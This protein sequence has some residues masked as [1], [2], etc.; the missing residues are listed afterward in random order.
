M[1]CTHGHADHIGCNYLFT[2]TAKVHIVGTSVSHGESFYLHDFAA[3][4]GSADGDYIID[5]GVCVRATPGHTLDSVSV[6]VEAADVA[7]SVAIVGDLFERAEDV[8]DE[9]VWRD[10]GTESVR[11]QRIARHCVAAAADA[12][13]PGHGP[14]FR[15]TDEIREQLTRDLD[16]AE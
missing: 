2:A 10:A 12:I 16:A 6:L 8:F 4:A 9:N 11:Q 7:P 1:V 15:V 14:M 3:A 5:E 13:V